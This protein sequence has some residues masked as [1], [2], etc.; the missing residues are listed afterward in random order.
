MIFTGESVYL[1]DNIYIYLLKLRPK[2]W[3]CKTKIET[4]LDTM[5]N[6]KVL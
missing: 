3:N 1:N 5:R 6:Y 2:I 4:N